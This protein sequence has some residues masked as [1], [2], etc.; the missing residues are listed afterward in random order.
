VGDDRDITSV[1]A[2]GLGHGGFEARRSVE[3]LRETTR[4]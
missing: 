4:N 3:R 1:V 2:E